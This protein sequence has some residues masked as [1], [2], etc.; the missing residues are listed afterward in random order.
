MP[1][2]VDSS[3]LLVF[4]YSDVAYVAFNDMSYK[5]TEGSGCVSITL[6]VMGEVSVEYTVVVDIIGGTATVELLHVFIA[7]NNRSMHLSTG[8]PSP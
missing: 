3:S 7:I 8:K 5:V 6:L 1:F 2:S 4:L